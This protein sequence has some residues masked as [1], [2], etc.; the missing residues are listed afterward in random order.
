MKRRAALFVLCAAGAGASAMA[1]RP[2]RRASK[3]LPPI[4]LD[5]QVPPAFAG[6]QIDRTL[7]PVLP[8]PSLQAALDKLYGQ[9]LARTY[10]NAQGQRVML[11]IAYGEDQGSDATAAHRPEFCYSA[12]G[13]SVQGLGEHRL[14]FGGQDLRVRRVVSTLQARREPITYWVT[15]N[16]SAVLP[17]FSRKVEQIRLG[18]QGQIPDGMLVRV[19]SISNT[20]APAFALQEQFLAALHDNLPPALRGRYFGSGTTAG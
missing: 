9:V 15:L 8:D 13:F 12:Q 10:I 19:S 5:K 7:V 20:D 6:W 2:Q 3:D 11:S 14:R 4:Q 18:L 16:N 1:L 17:G